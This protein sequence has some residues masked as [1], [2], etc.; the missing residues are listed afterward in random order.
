MIGQS[1]VSGCFSVESTSQWTSESPKR[2][3]ALL[4]DRS[5]VSR[6]QQ[7]EERERLDDL[8]E[9][10]VGKLLTIETESVVIG[11]K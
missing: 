8:N 2:G 9:N 4:G 10:S 11:I 5:K 7:K 1:K 6:R 3:K